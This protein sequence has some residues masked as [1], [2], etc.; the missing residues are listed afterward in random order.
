M[1]GIYTPLMNGYNIE[2]FVGY[3]RLQYS[4]EVTQYYMMRKTSGCWGESLFFLSNAPSPR[5]IFAVATIAHI[6]SIVRL[7]SFI[8][9]FVDHSDSNTHSEANWKGKYPS[10]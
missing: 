3:S 5:E 6:L 10:Y 2:I 1:L 8:Q 9:L 4:S 7:S